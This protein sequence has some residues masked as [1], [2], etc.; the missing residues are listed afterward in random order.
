MWS[1]LHPCPQRGRELHRQQAGDELLVGHTKPPALPAAPRGA[2]SACGASRACCMRAA[3]R[4]SPC[5]C[6]PGRDDV[7]VVMASVAMEP[8]AALPRLTQEMVLEP[9]G[10]TPFVINRGFPPP[11]QWLNGSPFPPFYLPWGGSED[12][13]WPLPIPLVLHQASERC[14]PKPAADG[15]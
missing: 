14:S 12:G 2:S 1:Q 7:R 9:W 3:L 5:S 13:A 6:R 4:R 15:G 10:E 11:V 8:G